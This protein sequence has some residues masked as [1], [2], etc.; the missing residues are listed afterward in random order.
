MQGYKNGEGFSLNAFK[1]SLEINLKAIQA[2]L[3]QRIGWIVII[4]ANYYR[5]KKDNH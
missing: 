5:Q 2:F 1:L 4:K 3:G